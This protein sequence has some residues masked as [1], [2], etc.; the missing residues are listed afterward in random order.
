MF[1]SAC[2]VSNFKNLKHDNSKATWI[3][4]LMLVWSENEINSKYGYIMLF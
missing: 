1:Q 4:F 2:H 3:M